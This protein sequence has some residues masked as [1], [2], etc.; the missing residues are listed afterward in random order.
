MT[1]TTAGKIVKSILK[2]LKLMHEKGVIHR[3]ISPDNIVG[4]TKKFSEQ[5]TL[6][7]FK[8]AAFEGLQAL[9]PQAGTPGFFAPETL[10]NK[11]PMPDPKEDVFSLGVVFYSLLYG[12]YLF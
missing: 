10:S 9:F 6:I 12:Q 1:E 8:F 4:S 3:N 5:S 7:D 2:S 11:N